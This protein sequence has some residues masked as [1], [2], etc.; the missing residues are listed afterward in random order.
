MI[1]HLQSNKINKLLSS[2]NLKVIESIDSIKLAEALNSAIGRNEN[3]IG[4]INVFVQVNTSNE[5]GD[6]QYL[7]SMIYL[8]NNFIISQIWYQS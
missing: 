5:E 6:Y 2:P 7:N 1:G 4:K 3:I 8:F